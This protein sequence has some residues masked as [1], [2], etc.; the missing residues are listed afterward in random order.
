MSSPSAETCSNDL[1]SWKVRCSTTA[2]NTINPIRN[3]VENIKAEPNPNKEVIMLSLGDPTVFGN[4]NPPQEAVDAI[5]EV[6]QRGNSNGYAASFGIKEARE[7]VAHFISKPEA[8]LTAD[9]IYLTCGCSDALNLAITVLCDQGDNIL[10]PRPGF[11]IYKT[12]CGSLGI[13]PRMYDCLPNKSWEIDLEHL[14]SLVDARTRAIIVVNP[15]NPCGSNFTREHIV[16][17]VKV[18]DKFKLPIIA[19]EIYADMV[20]NGKTFHS[21]AS[22]S[23]TVPVL[24]CGGIA[25]RFLVPGWRCGWVAVHDRCE[26]FGNEIRQGLFKLSQ[27]ILGPCTLVQA[28]LPAILT[29]TPDTFHKDTL[30]KLEDAAGAT[31]DK[32]NQIEGITPVRPDAAMYMMVGFDPVFFPEIHGDIEFTEKLISEQ[33]VMCLPAACF[34]YPN[35]FRLVLTV[36]KDKLMEACTRIDEFCSKHRRRSSA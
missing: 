21:M 32:L 5:V 29:K 2:E 8:Q 35:F 22:V 11:S 34:E 3:T 17:I 23:T 33:S 18:A 7:A 25:K 10:M 6:V 1:T 19:D 31:F 9:D 16:E 12:F 36:P 14:S 13:D 24:E 27:R 28:A 20:F 15:S 4:F 30:R 26:A